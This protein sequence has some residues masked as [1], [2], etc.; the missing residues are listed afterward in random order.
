MSL[1][2][3]ELF[4]LPD[5][6]N[7]LHISSEVLLAQSVVF[8][9]VFVVWTITCLVFFYLSL[10][11]LSFVIWLLIIPW[12]SF[13]LFRS[14][15]LLVS[16]KVAVYSTM[17]PLYMETG[18]EKLWCCHILSNQTTLNEVQITSLSPIF[19]LLKIKVIVL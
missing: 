19:V 2:E 5:N 10:Y 4:S 7:S 16:S 18:W 6:L 1:G 9:E 15:K 11:C 8:Y 3:Q 14:L 12:A 13:K 17:P